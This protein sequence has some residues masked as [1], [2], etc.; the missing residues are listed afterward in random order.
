MTNIISR[1]ELQGAEKY[2]SC[3][4]CGK[5]TEEREIYKIEFQQDGYSKNCS[6]ISL[7]WNCMM[8]LGN[9]IYEIHQNECVVEE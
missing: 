8:S 9:T 4:N 7:C 1:K 3:C 6:S 2:G 5:G